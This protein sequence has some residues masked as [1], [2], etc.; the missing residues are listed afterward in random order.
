MSLGKAAVYKHIPVYYPNHVGSVGGIVGLIGGLGGFILPITFGIMN[1]LL[2]VWTSCFMLLTVLVGAAL[3][4]MHFA[5]IFSMRKNHPELRGPKFLPE[6]ESMHSES[7]ATYAEGIE[8]RAKS[9]V[10]KARSQ[11]MEEESQKL[12]YESNLL[13]KESERLLSQNKHASKKSK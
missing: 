11:A 1:D 3:V 10:L 6:L 5:I 12:L 7:I 4:W 2:G 8:K 13:K 9:E